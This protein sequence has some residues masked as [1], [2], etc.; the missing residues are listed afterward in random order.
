M[1]NGED[2]LKDRVKAD[3]QINPVDNYAHDM[4]YVL[5]VSSSPNLNTEQVILLYPSVCMFEGVY[6]NH[7]RGTYDPFTVLGSPV[8]KGIYDFN[9]TPT[10][11]KGMADTYIYG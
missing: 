1:V 6:I 8:Y 9:F 3:I 2:W 7:G 4:R 10:G 11:I 5:P